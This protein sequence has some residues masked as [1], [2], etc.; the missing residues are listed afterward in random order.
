MNTQAVIE[1]KL[2]DD[3]T[4][5]YIAVENESHMH[6]VPDNSETHFKL[7][8]VSEVFAGLRAVQRHQRIYKLLA[9]ELQAGVHALA[10][11]TYAPNEWSA[12]EQA[13]DSPECLGGD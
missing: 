3:L 2:R 8:V 6:N 12:Q 5:L 11:H 9:E 13:P 10:I 1:K 7:V 4:P